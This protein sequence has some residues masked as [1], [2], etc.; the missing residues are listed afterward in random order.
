MRL[1]KFIAQS[2]GISRREADE[3]ISTGAI[4]V[5]GIQAELGKPVLDNDIVT[6]NGKE[7]NLP[8]SFTY[9]LLDKPTG[10]V[11]TR[12]SQDET[13]TVY[14]LIP[15][16]YHSL[17]YVGRL[18]KDSSGLLL[19]TNDG[20]YTHQM[21]HPKFGKSKTYKLKLSRDLSSADM[22]NVEKGIVLDDGFSKFSVKPLTSPSYEVVMREGRNRQIRRTFQALGY[23]VMSLRRTVFGP[24][25][26]NDLDGKQFKEVKK[27]KI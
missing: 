9:L 6:L 16:K 10:H 12:N 26:L 15:E 14:E 2:T 19:L 4:S 7:I 22:A 8:T 11:C 21:T 25:N 18:D 17:K 13:P 24:Y 20:D 27:H 5:N 3:I 1:N 23:S